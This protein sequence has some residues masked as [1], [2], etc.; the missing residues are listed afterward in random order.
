MIVLP[1]K[2]HIIFRVWWGSVNLLL[3]A[4]MVSSLYA[5]VREYSVRRY[6]DGFSDAIF[7]TPE[8]KE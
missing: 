7:S 1:T 6:L 8:I 4:V 3:V 5:G 2:R